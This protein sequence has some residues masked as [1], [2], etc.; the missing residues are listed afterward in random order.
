M[1]PRGGC[2]PSGLLSRGAAR[3]RGEARSAVPS[4]GGREGPPL[5]DV[6][7]VTQEDVE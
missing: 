4:E 7:S 1:K 5:K 6:M 2:E 3:G